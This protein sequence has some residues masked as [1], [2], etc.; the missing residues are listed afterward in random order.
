MELVSKSTK[1]EVNKFV[2][3]EY[4]QD[5]QDLWDKITDMESPEIAVR[6][7]ELAVKLPVHP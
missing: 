6:G 4:T 3:A 5:R 1:K 2:E 7:L